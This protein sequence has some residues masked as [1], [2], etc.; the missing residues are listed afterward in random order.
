MENLR[1]SRFAISTSTMTRRDF[2]R[3]GSM[4]VAAA[5]L[6]LAK[7]ANAQVK[8][9]NRE[10]KCIL[11]FLVGGPSQLDTWDLKPDAPSSIR[12]PFK[13]I[14]TNVPG[15]AICEHFP[16]TATMA[17][18][19]AIVRSVHHPEA[20]IHET[21]QQMMQ[22]GRVFEGSAEYPHYGAVLSWL[23]GP[24]PSG[25]PPF[26]VLPGPMGFTGAAL[27]HGQGSGCLGARHEPFWARPGQFHPR[28]DLAQESEKRRLRYGQNSFGQSC[29]KARQL[30]ERGARFV[31]VNMGDTIFNKVSWDCHADGGSLDSSLDDYRNTLCPMFDRAYAA[32][33]EDL[34]QR[35]LLDSTLVVA[36]GEFGRTPHLNPRGGRD[37][38][39]GVWSVLFAGGGIRGGQVVGSSDAIGAEPHDRPVSGAEI[40]ATIFH[41]LGIDPAMNLPGNS[42]PL[43]DAA[44]I[45]ELF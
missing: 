23:R 3:A 39:P 33:L 9:S 19:F 29:L 18:R 12:G 5:R 43:A 17:D 45:A 44:P 30:V 8:A 38:W 2:L 14:H 20:L 27:S 24:V 15:V 25:L 16:L 41:S 11:M 10:N 21:G 40:A 6:S 22:T 31:A 42:L 35:G 28:L 26:A 4:G 1:A 7:H 13:P 36:L 32:L 37:H 34:Q